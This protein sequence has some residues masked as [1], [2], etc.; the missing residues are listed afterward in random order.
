M[1]LKS[2][3]RH[4]LTYLAGFGAALASWNLIAPDQVQAVNEAGGQLVEPLMI[5]IGA[6]AAFLMRAVMLKLGSLF[7][8]RKNQERGDNGG[9]VSGGALSLLLFAGAAVGIMGCLPSCSASGWDVS[10]TD[11]MTDTTI[12]ITGGK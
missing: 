4:F 2:Q 9:G 6:I 12:L 7:S 1:N 5:I 11:P 10:Y 3:L 8:D